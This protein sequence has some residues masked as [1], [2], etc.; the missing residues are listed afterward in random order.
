MKHLSKSAVLWLLIAAL[1][2]CACQPTPEQDAVKQKDTNVLIDSVIAAD[3]QKADP[4]V[5]QEP[6]PE[7]FVCDFT[8]EPSGMHIYG[9]VP[10]RVMSENGTF[11]VLRVE[12][13]TLTDAQRLA[14]AERLCKSD[15]LYIWEYHETKEELTKRIAELMEEPTEADKQRWFADDPSSTEEEWQAYLA[16]REALVAQYQAQ[17]RALTDDGEFP[18]LRQWNGALP[19][20]IDSE[21]MGWYYLV[22]TDNPGM[23]QWRYDR[24]SVSSNPFGDLRFEA[25]EEDDLPAQNNSPY[26]FTERQEG[27]YRIA[28]EDYDTPMRKLRITP[29]EAGEIALS[30]ME[31][32]GDFAVESIVWS[33]NAQTDGMYAGQSGSWAYRVNLTPVYRGAQLHCCESGAANYSGS[34]MKIWQYESASVIVSVEGQ[35]RGFLWHSPQHRVTD[36]ISEDAQLLPFSEIL[37]IFEQQTRLTFAVKDGITGPELELTCAQLGL[38]RIREKNE[39]DSGLLV[40]AWFFLGKFHGGTRG[41]FDALNPYMIINALDGTIIDP[42]SGY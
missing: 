20:Q 15:A 36:T 14:L 9:D 30:I 13:G 25:A 39:V 38:F 22:S 3:Q 11:P 5:Q 28:A 8:V 21:R 10:I 17:Y 33:N 2:L 26:A 18:A 7:R 23:E 32:F 1:L 31:G 6:I 40:P 24:F 19:I 37:S 29:R 35:I 41:D 42:Y 12:Q 27:A 34:Y 16:E 4:D